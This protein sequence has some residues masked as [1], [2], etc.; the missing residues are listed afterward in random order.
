MR[1]S[2][3]SAYDDKTRVFGIATP[4]RRA[5]RKPVWIFQN[6]VIP[7]VES[8]IDAGTPNPKLDTPLPPLNLL[9]LSGE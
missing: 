5:S 7:F 3:D 8:S 2:K 4:G 6:C 9:V 1:F